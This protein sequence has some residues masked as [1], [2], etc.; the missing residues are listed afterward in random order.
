MMLGLD[1][2]RVNDDTLNKIARTNNDVLKFFMMTSL[3]FILHLFHLVLQ[4]HRFLPVGIFLPM[5]AHHTFLLVTTTK[6]STL[7]LCQDTSRQDQRIQ[8]SLFQHYK[9]PTHLVQSRFLL[10]EWRSLSILCHRSRGCHASHKVALY[11]LLVLWHLLVKA[12][13]SHHAYPF[14]LHL[15][16][17]PEP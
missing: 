9:V 4:L 16:G 15:P 8:K 11:V 10:C 2:P 1:C 14:A 3:N 7:S 5:A 6:L 13:Y 17:L 12:I